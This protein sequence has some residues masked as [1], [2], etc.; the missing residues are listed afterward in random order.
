MNKKI[1]KTLIIIFWIAVWG[2]IAAIIASP[3]IFA[4]PFDTLKSLYLEIQKTEFWLTVLLS[5][6][7]ITVGFF[8]AFIIGIV[9]AFS[10]YKIKIINELLSP[11]MQLLK[12]APIVCFIVLLLVWFGTNTVDIITIILAVTPI[13]FFATYQAC[14]NHNKLI[15]KMLKTYKVPARTSWKV[16]YWPN[17]LPFI[18]QATQTGIGI[19]WKSGVT[20]QMIGAVSY[21]VGAGVYLSK[22][23]LDSAL[24]LVW[25]FVVIVLSWMC[26]KL[27]IWILNISNKNSIEKE[28]KR[29]HQKVFNKSSNP[30]VEI[31][32]LSIKFDKVLFEN[33]NL[34]INKGNKIAYTS[35]TGTGKTTLINEII[36]AGKC[37]FSVVFQEDT[38]LKSLTA[39]ENIIIATQNPN[40]KI[41]LTEN[42]Y[43]EELSGGQ[44][45]LVQI[46]RALTAD[47]DVVILDEPFTG[48]DSGTKNKAINYINNNID[49]RALVL[50]TH[51]EEDANQLHA[52]I[53][54]L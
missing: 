54:Q 15:A 44:K 42:R 18:H 26:E 16:F 37:K 1:R 35:E 7:R 34:T 38:L 8:F 50:V 9:L 47:S 6:T 52:K 25:M 13:Y 20:A 48:L 21:T 39:L 2:A 46:E 33:L 10:S 19:S 51:D 28:V 36:K 30:L 49:D 22:L 27:I 5:L 31:K 24:L 11:L 12:S 14:K 41:T 17:A 4:S 23:N 29:T 3:I 45:R 40:A 32:N 43:P 53:N